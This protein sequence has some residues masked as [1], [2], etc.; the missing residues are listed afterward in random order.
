M[1]FH[2]L[3]QNLADRVF[4][5]IR[6]CNGMQGIARLRL[7]SKAWLAAVQQY[8]GSA[9]VSSNLKAL[10]ALQRIMPNVSKLFVT[11]KMGYPTSFDLTPLTQCCQLSSLI[12]SAG[13]PQFSFNWDVIHVVGIPNTVR[14]VEVRHLSLD[15]S[16]FNNAT[17]LITKLTYQRQGPSQNNE[18]GF[19]Q[20]LPHLKV[21]FP[22]C[23]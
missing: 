19:L 11:P 14:E 8:P 21:Q 18:W 1:Q 20:H 7:V 23:Y 15:A 10:D 16:S 9:K 13:A 5:I 3:P 17:A 4:D 22:P 12:L 2:H 6:A